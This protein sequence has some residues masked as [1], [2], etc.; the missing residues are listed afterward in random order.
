MMILNGRQYKAVQI[1]TVMTNP[2][3]QGKGL[4]RQLMEKVMEDHVDTNIIYLFANKTVLDFYP[5]FGFETRTQSTFTVD[6]K[7]IEPVYTEVKKVNLED[8]PTR[9]IFY[10]TTVFRKPVSQKMSMIQNEN[11]VMFHALTQYQDC[12]YYVPKFQAF[13]I[14]NE[15]AQHAELIDVISKEPVNIQE[16]LGCLPIQS[17]QIRL[18]FTPD[19]IKLPVTQDV[20]IDDGA[21]FVKNQIDI[22]YPNNLLYPY[23]GLA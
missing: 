14:L 1:G 3:F 22:V 23:S 20:F 9:N 11:I 17:E 10:E 18:C 12:I 8:K 13:V 16:I 4:S 7:D 6:K 21:M 2:T 15:T 19:D 5:K